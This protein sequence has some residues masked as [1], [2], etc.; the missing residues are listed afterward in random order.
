M[1]IA[2]VAASAPSHMYPHLAMVHELVRRGHRLSY[3]VGGHLAGLATPT[4][5]DVIPCT[6]VLPGAPGAPETFDESD[7]VAG[8]RMF[9][10]EAVHVLP[11]LHDALDADRPD[12]VLYDIGGMAGPVAADRWGVPA[13]QLSPSEV[14]WDGYHDDMAEILG[15]ILGSPA[16]LAYR[17]AFDDW[18]TESEC[19]LTFDDVTG[20]PRRCLVLIP[21]VMQRHADRVGDRYRFVGPCIDPR[22]GDP[23]DWTPPAG[24]GPLALLA[25]GTAYTE[26]A[27]V[28]RNVIEALDGQGWRLVL[29]TGRADVGPVPPWVQ[30]RESV[31]QPAVLQQADCFITHA[32]MGSCTEGLWFGVPMVA[33]PQAVDQPANAARLETIG[34]GRHLTDH[35]PSVGDIREAVLGVAADP[36]IRRT[37]DTVRA[38]IHAHGGPQHAADTVED[39]VAGC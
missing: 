18:L 15:P 8:M 25:F 9:L 26:R 35:L 27:D 24:D 6:S 14:A 16:G 28:Y 32:G 11:Q 12:L 20:A 17:R 31:P 36:Q 38:E 5:A 21:R 37:L 7:P 10:D 2:V 22:R 4:G 3:L 39:I 13:A 23:G 33:I 34:V 1:H 30:T 19:S 29:A